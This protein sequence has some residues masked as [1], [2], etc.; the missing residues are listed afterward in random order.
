MRRSTD[1][2]T[3]GLEIVR[4]RSRYLGYG[5]YSYTKETPMFYLLSCIFRYVCVC[6]CACVYARAHTV[7]DWTNECTQVMSRLLSYT[8]RDLVTDL[9]EAGTHWKLLSVPSSIVS[10]SLS[11]LPY[12]IPIRLSI[13]FCVNLSTYLYIYL[14]TYLSNSVPVSLSNC[15]PCAYPP[16][17]LP[18]F[19]PLFNSH[20]VSRH[21]HF[22]FPISC[23]PIHSPH[24]HQRLI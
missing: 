22:T 16:I 1:V 9:T 3:T 12:P 19:L 18:L 10:L 13:Y 7:T 2:T 15:P 5:G 4:T 14:S 6:V 11:T 17:V 21:K 24:P 8:P 23:Y 20:P